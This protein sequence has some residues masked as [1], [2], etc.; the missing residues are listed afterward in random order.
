MQ[1]IP[2][3]TNILQPPKDD[4]FKAIDQHCPKLQ[5]NDIICISSKALAIHQ[6]RCVPMEGVDKQELIKKHAQAIWPSDHP[7]LKD[8]PMTIVNNTFSPAAGIDE[9]NAN[10]HYVLWPE[11]TNQ[12]AKKICN[13]LKEK[14]VVTNLAVIICDSY[15][16]P[17]R[18]GVIGISIGHFGI[19]AIKDY[20]GEKDIFGREIDFSQVNIVDILASLGTLAM[21]EGNEQ[22]PLAIIRN[23]EY[24]TFTN[25]DTSKQ[26][27]I[28][29]N[30]DLYYPLIKDNYDKQ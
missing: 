29:P 9:S 28:P 26:L 2:V 13:Y 24:A 19:N 22:Q 25:E 15:L 1:I 14:Y 6:G 3:K 5:E 17:M 27:H 30:Y 8:I 21:G 18:F 23:C 7:A 4:L 16:I 20:R 11:N 10:N 12:S